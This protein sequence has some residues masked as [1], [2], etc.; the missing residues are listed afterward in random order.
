MSGWKYA[1]AQPNLFL[2]LDPV[3]KSLKE[4]KKTGGRI[5]NQLKTVSNKVWRLSVAAQGSLKFTGNEHQS[6]W[7]MERRCCFVHRVWLMFIW[8]KRKQG[9]RKL[10]VDLASAKGWEAT[11]LCFH[12]FFILLEFY[13][14]TCVL[15]QGIF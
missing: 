4:Q 10:A 11:V 8:T 5:L 2:L 13:T 15:H 12:P 14:R 3:E 6:R 9:S 1:N 7:S